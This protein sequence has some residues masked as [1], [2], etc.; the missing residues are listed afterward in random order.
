MK[1]L[2]TFLAIV[3]LIVL[4]VGFIISA[5]PCATSSGFEYNGSSTRSYALISAIDEFY[6]THRAVAHLQR[7]LP[8]YTIWYGVST[9]VSGTAVARSAYQSNA[10]GPFSQ[11]G[12]YDCSYSGYSSGY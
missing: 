8:P 3:F 10:L 2:P 12:T 4:S 1:K 7:T 5:D 11:W 6:H 9:F